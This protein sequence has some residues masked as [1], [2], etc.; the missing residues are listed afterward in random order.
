MKS[1]NRGAQAL[2]NSDKKAKS[3][4]A[5]SGKERPRREL[6]SLEHLRPSLC[7]ELERT[8]PI[9]GPDALISRTELA[10]YGSLYL[11]ELL[12]AEHGELTELGRQVAESIA[13]RTRWLRTS[14]RSL[15]CGERSVNGFPITSQPLA[16]AGPSLSSSQLPSRPGSRSTRSCPIRRGSH[17]G[18]RGSVSP[19][20]WN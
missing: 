10:R 6:V 2:T 20:C 3:I 14:T 12:E 17:L 5:I 8:T 11:E 15:R 13:A 9:S 16:A 4:C 7:Q 19:S 1:S 18:P